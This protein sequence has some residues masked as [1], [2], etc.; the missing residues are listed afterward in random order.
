MLAKATKKPDTFDHADQLRV[1]ERATYSRRKLL[2]QGE[3]RLLRVLDD[4]CT[5]EGTG[6]RVM[7]Q[8]SLGEV[9]A[10][11]DEAAYRAI[12][13]KRVDMLLID[14]QGIPHHAIEL[15]GSGHH[16][17]PAATRDAIEKEALRRAGIGYVEV[18]PGD[19]PTEIRARVAKLARRSAT[20]ASALEGR[21]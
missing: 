2:N 12:N 5:A 6:W 17:G 7:A 21:T 8:V 4:I 14:D 1:V 10:T 16:L 13:T 9:L 19:T 18:M 11:P 15:Q 20:V 3:R